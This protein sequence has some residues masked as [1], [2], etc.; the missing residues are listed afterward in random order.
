MAC[1]G[2]VYLGKRKEL[3]KCRSITVTLYVG[4]GSYTSLD[5]KTSPTKIGRG[6]AAYLLRA[7][8][9]FVDP[10]TR[11]ALESYAPKKRTKGDI[12]YHLQ[13]WKRPKSEGK[14]V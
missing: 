11:C 12:E 3:K 13:P 7:A 14:G 9:S 5:I 4:D 10:E 6:A 2:G 1:R 8:L